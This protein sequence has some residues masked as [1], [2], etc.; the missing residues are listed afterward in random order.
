MSA[1][2]AGRSRS[3]KRNASNKTGTTVNARARGTNA[4]ARATT[5]VLDL[6]DEGSEIVDGDDII[7]LSHTSAPAPAET[8]PAPIS[9]APA[10]ALPEPDPRLL[11]LGLPVE[12]TPA[13]AT[14]D[15][16][17]ALEHRL[18]QLPPAPAVPRT[19]GVVIAIVGIGTDP[20]ALARRLADELHVGPNHVLL[21]TPEA[22]S[23]LSQPE[24]ADAFRRTRRRRT[25]PTIVA[26]SI[27]T[28]RA[29]LGW[30]R[31][32]LARLEPTITWAVVDASV[33]TED[34]A[35]RIDMLGVVDVVALN[36]VA[37]TTSPAAP[38]ALGI[39]VGRVGAR[40][41]TPGLWT[42]MLMERLEQ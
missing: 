24:D 12:L 33:K 36:G 10:P 2:P 3:G 11:A 13:T 34:L 27:G 20:I 38:L 28:G 19:R 35:Q 31:R 37:D 15:L 5:P 42:T 32:I 26:C 25:A 8:A 14:A 39:P 18:S 22:M 23:C 6:V 17:A 41:A 30:T 1:A 21:Q 29:Q 7:D 16:R 40:T 9:A 4:R